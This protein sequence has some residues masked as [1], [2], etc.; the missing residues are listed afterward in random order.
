MLSNNNPFIRTGVIITWIKSRVGMKLK[1]RKNT[2]QELQG[3]L[4]W[5]YAGRKLIDIY[6]EIHSNKKNIPWNRYFPK[7]GNDTIKVLFFEKW[8]LH[9][10]STKKRWDRM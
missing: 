2:R 8:T 5:S 3:T 7:E 4:Y 1:K 9:D 10:T 6:N